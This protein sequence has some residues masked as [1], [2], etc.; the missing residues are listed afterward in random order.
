M[1]KRQMK[2][3]VGCVLLSALLIASLIPAAHAVSQS[4]IDALQAKK[5][6]LSERTAEAEQRVALLQDEQATVLDRKLALDEQEEA[7][8][9]SL[10]LVAE[11]I[12]MYN[13]II[14]EKAAELET[15]LRREE[16]QLEKYRTRVRALEESG[17]YNIL[18]V[19]MSSTDF[20]E[21]LTAVDDMETIMISDRDL[22]DRYI[23]AREEA[24]AVKAEYE[25]VRL[26]CEEKQRSLQGEKTELEQ[27]LTITVEKL[28]ELEGQL[29]EAIA[30]YEQA[31]A[32]EEAAAQEVLNMIA[33]YEKQKQQEAAAR[34][35]QQAQQQAASG[36][37]GSQTAAAV[38]GTGSFVWPVPCSTRITSRFGYRSDPF[39]GETKYHSGIDIDGYGNEGGSVLAADGGTVTTATYSDGYGN[40]III[41]HGNGYQTLY[42][43]MSGLAVGAGQTVSQGQTIGY[44]GSTGRATGTHC[45]F[46]VFINGDRTDPTQFFS[47]LTYYNC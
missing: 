38:V 12:V 9:E 45:H 22:E 20:N 28:A 3:T 47:G 40:Y 17:G 35:A 27:Q 19:F 39:T 16:D 44:L 29:E 8:K 41:D 5:D 6:E 15:A 11:E 23:E 4:E 10:D 7:L 2:R 13:R 26:S 1:K 18:A 36:S 30:T 34:A 46:E 25:S 31:Q 43:H 37:A 33:A 14:E 42:G 24:E 32:A 21:F